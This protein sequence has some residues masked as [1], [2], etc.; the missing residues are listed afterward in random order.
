M[1][2]V[3]FTHIIN[4][5]MPVFPG[6]PQPQLAP[7]SAFET[8]GFR[9]TLLHLS[10]HT[11]THM[12]AP[13]HV[14]R[15]GATLDTYPI[16]QFTGIGLVIDCTGIAKGQPIDMSS[17][18]AVSGLAK[19]AEF[20]LFR[21]GWSQYWGQKKYFQDY[22]CISPDVGEYIVQTHKKGVGFDTIGIDPVSDTELIRHHQLLATDNCVIVENLTNLDQGGSGL[23]LFTV[24][25]LKYEKSD[26]AP[27]RA[28]GFIG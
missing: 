25:P 11:G 8:E 4:N 12:D 17:I 21:T 22:P 7:A 2:V 18:E 10:S 23:F 5:K 13:A 28:I 26:G 15:Q 9:E 24:L 20:L 16:E 14:F 3:D 6:T 19:Q 1:K 27:V